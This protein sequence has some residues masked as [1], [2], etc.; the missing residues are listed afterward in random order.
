MAR[1]GSG[2]R[3]D[4]A[5][6]TA[7][8]PVALL[9]PVWL[10]A[11]A[12]FWWPFW[13]LWQGPPYW[14][15]VAAHLALGVALL[16]RPVAQRFLKRL[17]GARA[18]S[19]AERRHLEPLFQAVLLHSRLGA[20]R[21]V[22]AVVDTDELNAFA[23]SG[24]LVVVTTGAIERLPPAELQGVLAHEIGHHLGV[25]GSA[26]MLGYWLALPV[27][28]LARIG[29]YLENVA[30][31]ATSAFAQTRPVATLF[32]QATALM[33]RG[34]SWVFVGAIRVWQAVGG[35]VTRRAEYRADEWAVRLG[36]GWELAAA[37]R[38]SVVDEPLLGSRSRADKVF[39]SHPP[40]RTRIARV[41]AMVRR[42]ARPA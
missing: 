33:L 11:L 41:E 18:P 2:K 15:A 40:L 20:K 23:S 26:L 34:L 21:F 31:A 24:R 5:S 13:A 29:M 7:F 27:V 38:R 10:L 30:T 28:A 14:L 9:A 37:M 8:V 32:G 3:F 6:I 39:G 22:I 25:E 12:A 4:A 17:L 36:F 19:A 16:Y 42:N 35:I 1:G